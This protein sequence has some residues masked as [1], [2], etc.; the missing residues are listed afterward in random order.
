[1]QLF[2]LMLLFLFQTMSNMITATSKYIAKKEKKC[3]I[4]KYNFACAFDF[5]TSDYLH[6]NACVDN[7]KFECHF[8]ITPSIFQYILQSLAKDDKYWQ[9]GYNGTMQT[10]INPDVKFLAVLKIILYGVSFG[11]FSDYFQMRESNA[12]QSV[13]KCTRG[14]FNNNY[15]VEKFMRPM[16]QQSC[17]SYTTINMEYLEWLNV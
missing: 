10:K 11:A 9:H 5:V 15:I 4:I 16:M 13:S 7:K 6:A 12:Q 1:M 8:W 2:S 14:V 17:Q 3:Q